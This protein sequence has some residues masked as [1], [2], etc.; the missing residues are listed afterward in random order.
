MV[1]DS[2]DEEEAPS[3]NGGVASSSDERFASSSQESATGCLAGFL[4]FGVDVVDV[5]VG[6]VCVVG[7]GM[8]RP[9]PFSPIDR[10][11]SVD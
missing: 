7:R 9:G 1:G 2:T 8:S 11:R 10:S 3:C 5:V 6:V 4:G